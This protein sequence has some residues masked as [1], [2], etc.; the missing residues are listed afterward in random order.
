MNSQSIDEGAQVAIIIVLS[1]SANREVT[2]EFNTDDGSAQAPSDYT[3]VLNRNVI[4][5]AGITAVTVLVDTLD[6]NIRESN[7][8]FSATLSN[9]TNDL[10]LGSQRNTTVVIV[11]GDRK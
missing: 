7:E 4:F 9:P 5:S 3:S 10:S 1:T 11:D 6:D 2:V 8:I